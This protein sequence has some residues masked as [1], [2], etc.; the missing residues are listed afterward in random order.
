MSPT[1]VERISPES[2]WMGN[3]FQFYPEIQS[4]L[5]LQDQVAMSKYHGVTDRQYG[6]T[7][8]RRNGAI[9]KCLK[10]GS[11]TVLIMGVFG[12]FRNG[13]F[14]GFRERPWGAETLSFQDQSIGAV[15]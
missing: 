10:W 14:G 9:S 7:D 11:R 1:L 8:V 4:F 3:P 2:C 13:I 6:A 5:A 15:T 12:S